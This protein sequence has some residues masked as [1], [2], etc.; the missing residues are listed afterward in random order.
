MYFDPLLT[1]Y[2]ALLPHLQRLVERPP[3]QQPTRREV[4]E[5]PVCYG[6]ELGPDLSNV[7]SFG[8][9]TEAEV[10][11]LHSAPTYQVL[12]IGFMPGFA[13][14][15]TVDARIAA[16]RLEK[17]RARVL[18]GSVGIAKGQTGVYPSD[19]PGGWRLIGRTPL[20]P[21]DISRP[22]PFLFRAG[23]AVRFVPI[24]RAEFERLERAS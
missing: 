13:Y 2:S 24:A 20:R 19:G 5:I 12:M 8:G 11:A 15:G 1:D 6:D 10:V 9:V 4:M 23:D 17:P 14:M 7:A 16:P 22:D 21:F 3:A 18:R